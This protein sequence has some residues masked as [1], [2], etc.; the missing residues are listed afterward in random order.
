M[1]WGDL[2]VRADGLATHLVDELALAE[3]ASTPDAAALAAVLGRAGWGP[4][5]GAGPE[6]IE[7]GARRRLA[8]DLHILARWTGERGEAL[9]VLLEDEDRLGLRAL[10]RGLAASAPVTARIAAVTP[11]PR[12]TEKLVRTLAEAPTLAA[13]ATELERSGHPY[14]EALTAADGAPPDLF[15]V[16]LALARRFA[17]RARAGARRAEPLA[18]YVAQVIDTDNAEAAPLLAARGDGIDPATCFVDGGRHLDRKRFEAAAS[19][20]VDAARLLDGSFAGT[21]LAAALRAPAAA[22]LEHAA[23]DWQI[24]TQRRLRRLDPTGPA[25]I[26]LLVLRRRREVRRVRHAAWR[27]ALGG[28]A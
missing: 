19:G 28:G 7:L 13:M 26:V 20:G 24:A 8:A 27:I 1:N 6:A 4:T 9:A 10:V 15:A 23:L 12:L 11:T 22:A 16:E 2:A 14:A 18:A 5:A 3:V 21:P 25:A 17:D